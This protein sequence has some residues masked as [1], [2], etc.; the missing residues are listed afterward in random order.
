MWGALPRPRL[1]A[2]AV[3]GRATD[4]AAGGL[5]GQPEALGQGWRRGALGQAAHRQALGGQR[6][7]RAGADGSK[8]QGERERASVHLRGRPGGQGQGLGPSGR[9]SS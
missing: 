7:G 9:R 3:A 4:S 6:A 1:P 8:L 2:P 5:E